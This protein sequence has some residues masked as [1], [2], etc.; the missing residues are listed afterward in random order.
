[1]A[2]GLLAA[3][4]QLRCHHV[5]AGSGAPYKL[6]NRIHA[7]TSFVGRWAAPHRAAR[8]MGRIEVEATT[9][10]FWD[11]TSLSRKGLCE[12][13]KTPGM[14]LLIVMGAMTRASLPASHVV[15]AI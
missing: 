5:F 11:N 6:V 14:T 7:E 4:G 2:A 9:S 8:Q 3:L 12:E 13:K 15:P 10:R 1:M